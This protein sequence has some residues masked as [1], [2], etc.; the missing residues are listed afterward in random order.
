MVGT[1]TWNYVRQTKAIVTLLVKVS[2]SQLLL[3]KV[4]E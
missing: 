2:S 4:P 1:I 3:V